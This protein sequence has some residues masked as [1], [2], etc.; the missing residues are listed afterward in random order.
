MGV[1]TGFLTNNPPTKLPFD[2]GTEFYNKPFLD[3]LKRLNIKHY[4][5]SSDR[6]CAIVE[7]FNRTLKTRLFR[8]FTAAGNHR[9]VDILDDVVSGYNNTVHSSIKHKPNDVTLANE[10]IIRKILYPRL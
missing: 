3:L 8:H 4:S 5:I 2:Q 1:M 10:G 7:R 9:Y 6:K